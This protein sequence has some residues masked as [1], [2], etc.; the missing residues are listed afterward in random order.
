MP[1]PK[2][3]FSIGDVTIHLFGVM[4]AMGFIA[5][6]YVV[7]HEWQRRKLP[8]AK[9]ADLAL[10]L[11]LGGLAGARALFVILNF[12]YFRQNP[13]HVLFIHQGGLA[14]HGAALA[15][16]A[17]VLAFARKNKIHFFQLADTLVPGLA[18][19]YAVGRIGCDIFGIPA[20]VPWA[21]VVD[22]VARHP[23]QLYSALAGYVIFAVLWTRRQ[24]QSYRGEM[25][26]SFVTMYSLYRFAVEFFRSGNGFTTAQY[27]SVAF[28][29]G[30]LAL[31]LFLKYKREGEK[32]MGG[33]CEHHRANESK[34]T[35]KRTPLFY[36]VLGAVIIIGL[37]YS[38]YGFR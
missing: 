23:V 7:N 14:F 2:I 3:L 10:Y 18:L 22:G 5:G 34:G 4:V 26:L 28:V 16:A 29:L 32:R 36:W 35:S 20:G 15:G 13:L 21:I 30:S 19:G 11:L 31:F 8:E 9:L 38:L 27:A 12:S 17:I 37:F 33:C 24:S 1:E 6:M 25:F